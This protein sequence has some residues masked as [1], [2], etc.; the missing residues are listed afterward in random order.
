MKSKMKVIDIICE[1]CVF[2]CAVFQW[3]LLLVV[4]QMAGCLVAVPSPKTPFK[5]RVPA[6]WHR[7]HTPCLE[8]HSS[9]IKKPHRVFAKEPDPSGE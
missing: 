9:W 8:E 6:S 5:T 1:L 7:G 4:L 3:A 2:P